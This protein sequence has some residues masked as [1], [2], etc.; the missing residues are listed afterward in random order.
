MERTPGDGWR[1]RRVFCSH[2]CGR[3]V[4]PD[5]VRA[6]I[7]G[8]VAWGCSVALHERARVADGAIATLNFDSYPILRHEEMPE[9]EISLLEPPGVPPAGAGEAALVPTPAAIANALFAATGQRVR[10]LPLELG[11]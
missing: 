9:V 11:G 7:E 3:V 2:D 10:G 4:S 5:Q 8:N 1:V 6:Q